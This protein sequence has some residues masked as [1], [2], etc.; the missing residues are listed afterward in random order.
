MFPFMS[1]SDPVA[2]LKCVEDIGGQGLVLAFLEM[3]RPRREHGG[4]C[5]H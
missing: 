5:V 1:K 2:N 3:R 4:K